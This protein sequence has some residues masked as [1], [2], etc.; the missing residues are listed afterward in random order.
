MLGFQWTSNLFLTRN[1]LQGKE[2]RGGHRYHDY[3]YAAEGD[4]ITVST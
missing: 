3:F 1:R 4:A 2:M